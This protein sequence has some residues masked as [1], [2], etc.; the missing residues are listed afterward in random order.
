MIRVSWELGRTP[1]EL[2]LKEI[3]IHSASLPVAAG[4]QLCQMQEGQATYNERPHSLQTI[5]DVATR[6][7]IWWLRR[8]DS[9]IGAGARR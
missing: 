8:K 6:I 1:G 7:T 4:T 5:R 9:W 2:P 3:N